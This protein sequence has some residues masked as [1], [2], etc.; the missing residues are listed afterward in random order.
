M[1][2]AEA[3]GSDTRKSDHAITHGQTQGGS[4]AQRLFRS[5]LKVILCSGGA[6]VTHYD[7]TKFGIVA[8][9]VRER[10]PIKASPIK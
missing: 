8:Q 10:Y 7:F 3:G 1:A 6:C 4:L 5:N 9:G 2:P